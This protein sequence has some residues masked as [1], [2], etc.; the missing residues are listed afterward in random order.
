MNHITRFAKG[1]RNAFAG[2]F[3]PDGKRIVLRLERAGKGAL[4]TVRRDGSGLRR[5]TTPS[6]LLPRF[7]DWSPVAP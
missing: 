2:S 3:S 4:A 1:S 6:E 7:I 5:L